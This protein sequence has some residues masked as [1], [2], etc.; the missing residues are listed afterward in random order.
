MLL[1][2]MPPNTLFYLNKKL[3]TAIIKYTHYVH[4]RRLEELFLAFIYI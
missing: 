3:I 2:Y 1:K 4:E